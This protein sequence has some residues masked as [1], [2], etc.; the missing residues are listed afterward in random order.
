MKE[1][2][3]EAKTKRQKVIEIL[4]ENGVNEVPE[5]LKALDNKPHQRYEKR[6]VLNDC[7]SL[8]IVC[9]PVMRDNVLQC[10]SILREQ[11]YKVTYHLIHAKKAGEKCD[12]RCFQNYNCLVDVLKGVL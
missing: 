12:V 6:V 8:M 11:C 2:T 4:E 7:T 9:S 1:K 3:K 10:G 5:I